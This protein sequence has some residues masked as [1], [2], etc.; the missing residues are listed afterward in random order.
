MYT[1]RPTSPADDGGSICENRSIAELELP[2]MAQKVCNKLKNHACGEDSEINHNVSRD[3]RR[4]QCKKKDKN[5]KKGEEE[6]EAE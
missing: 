1:H 5:D 6:G 4:F 2:G 3:M